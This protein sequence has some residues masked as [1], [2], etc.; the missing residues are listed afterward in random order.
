LRTSSQETIKRKIIEAHLANDLE[1]QHSKDWILA[2]YLNTAPYGT[3]NGSTAIGVQAAA[4]TYFSKSAKNLTLPEVALIAG[5][6]QAPSQYNPFNDPKAALQRRN[7]VL[8]AMQ[9]QGYITLA[10]YVQAAHSSLGLN[11]SH[12]FEKVKEPLIFDLVQQQLI[13]K[14]GINTVRYA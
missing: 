9:G 4:Q 3:N 13:D 5:L 7:D 14:Y 1:A 10:Q 11:A 2:K 12:K 6:P 8:Q